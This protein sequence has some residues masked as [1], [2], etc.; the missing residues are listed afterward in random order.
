M[1]RAEI[2]MTRDLPGAVGVL[3]IL[4]DREIGFGVPIT[5]SPTSET[6]VMQ[7]TE[8]NGATSAK[9]ADCNRQEHLPQFASCSARDT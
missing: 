2:A 3:E 6:S 5:K 9:A 4:S 7:D 8:A 1:T